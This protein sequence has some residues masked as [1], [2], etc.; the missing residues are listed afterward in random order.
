MMP[1]INPST[2]YGY[3]DT[4]SPYIDGIRDLGNEQVGT[5]DC[6]KVEV[7]IMDGQRSWYLW[8]SQRDH[9]PRKQKQIVRVSSVHEMEEEWSDVVINAD[10]PDELFQWSPPQG[11][12]EWVRA[13]PDDLLLG[14]GTKAPEFDLASA[15]GERIKLAD[16]RGQVVWLYIWR[17]GCPPCR[18]G[19]RDVQDF[20]A[21]YRDQGLVVLGLNDSDEKSIA[22]EFLQEKGATFPNILDSSEAAQTL[23]TKDYRT[24]GVPVNYVIDAQGNVVDAW[25]GHTDGHARE[26]AALQQAGLDVGESVP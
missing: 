6:H 3:N 23:T 16:F 21:K 20:Y 24:T 14:R 18:E 22:L 2:F 15:S 25:Y 8:L 12:T 4:L 17:A 1:I 5:E 11:W 26:N 13:E 7:S 9:L 19:L 10:L